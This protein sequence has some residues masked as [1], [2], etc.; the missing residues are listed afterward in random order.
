MSGVML[1][2]DHLF[3]GIIAAFTKGIAPQDTPY[4]H[5]RTFESSVLCDR[6]NSIFRTSRQILTGRR[7]YWGYKLLVSPDQPNKESSDHFVSPSIHTPARRKRF[8][9]SF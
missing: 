7:Q 4:G 9:I 1:T 8:L 6:I 5:P 3:K 2:S